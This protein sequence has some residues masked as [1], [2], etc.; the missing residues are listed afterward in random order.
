MG[1]LKF[2]GAVALFWAASPAFA[3]VMQPMPPSLAYEALS[4]TFPTAFAP[5]DYS[6]EDFTIEQVGRPI[7]GLKLELEPGSLEW[8]RVQD[9]LVLP[10]ARVRVTYVGAAKAGSVSQAGFTQPLVAESESRL[11]AE[12]PVA[13]ISGEKNEIRVTIGETAAYRV[14]FSPRAASPRGLI[15]VDPSCSR[16]GV[17]AVSEK[18]G[19][20]ADWMYVGCRL[21]GVE[22]EKHRT[23]SLELFV[24]WEKPSADFAVDGHPLAPASASVW[25]LRL[26]SKPGTVRLAGSS[27]ER[28][29]EIKYG[30]P[31]QLKRGSLGV[32]IGPY[33][34]HYQSSTEE[35][36]STVPIMTLYGSYQVH[37]TI[38][39][40]AFNATT[41]NHQLQTDTG[42]YI[43]AEQFRTLDRRIGLSLMLGANLKGVRT[44][45]GD[46]LLLF[47]AP[48]GFELIFSDFLGKN[49]N[50]GAGAFIYPSISGNAYYNTWVRWGSP[51]FF[52]EI[53]FISWE[54]TTQTRGRF[55]T[56]S[57]GVSIGFPLARFL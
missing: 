55:Y 43:N 49:R 35:V 30:I 8:V 42:L 6:T 52:G 32:G 2:L 24:L 19:E 34:Y 5:A 44:D 23:S 14:R 10:R 46:Y 41:F 1:N 29:I 40:A 39:I 9:V 36:Q 51:A 38:R 15:G 11:T 18:A 50:L 53:N 13:L 45:E 47:G 20:K 4:E 25:L 22:G 28:G 33:S 54:Q 48:Q 56:R 3:A 26:R 17:E 57:F 27:G 21:I 12:I 37:D 31:E 7:G 16:Y